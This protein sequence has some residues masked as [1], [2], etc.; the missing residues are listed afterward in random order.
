VRARSRQRQLAGASIFSE[1]PWLPS[2]SVLA[3]ATTGTRA[4]ASPP[5]CSRSGVPRACG[6]C[7][8]RR[9]GLLEWREQ[10]GAALM[11]GRHARHATATAIAALLEAQLPCYPEGS[12][13][14]RAHRNLTGEAI[15]VGSEAIVSIGA[16]APM[17]RRSRGFRRLHV[18][19]EGGKVVWWSVLRRQSRMGTLCISATPLRAERGRAAV[20]GSTY[21]ALLLE[22]GAFTTNVTGGVAHSQALRAPGAPHTPGAPVREGSVVLSSPRTACGALGEATPAARSART[23]GGGNCF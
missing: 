16:P 18:D 6:E 11:K 20:A 8:S 21:R 14:T 10:V 3:G 23:W 7:L 15:A 2:G 17:R 13:V 22:P 1:L 19:R 12:A 5:P 4:I 9:G